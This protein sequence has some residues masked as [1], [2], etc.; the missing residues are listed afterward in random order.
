MDRLVSNYR[1]AEQLSKTLHIRLLSAIEFFVPELKGQLRLT[2]EALRGRS[3]N[4]PVS[5]TIPSTSR[6]AFLFA[7]KAGSE[8]KPHIGVGM[9]AQVQ[10][11]FRADELTTIRRR[12]VDIPESH[13]EPI[14]IALGTI[15]LTKVKRKQFVRVTF[16]EHF[17]TFMLLRVL[18]PLIND[19]DQL[20]FGFSY[21]QFHGAIQ[22]YDTAFGLHIGLSGHSGRACFATEAVII[23]NKPTPQVMREGRWL[24]E[25]SFRTYLDAIGANAAQAKFASRGLREAADFCRARIFDYLTP[26]SL[27]KHYGQLAEEEAN[28]FGR[29]VKVEAEGSLARPPRRSAATSLLDTS[30]G[31][32]LV[33]S[34]GGLV[35][36]GDCRSRAS[37]GKGGRG[38]G[39]G[40]R[41]VSTGLL[42]LR[43]GAGKA[44]KGR[45]KKGSILGK[46]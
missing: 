3:L 33:P 35:Q 43:A 19:P 2:K 28:R 38:K 21:W 13:L 29:P 24:S 40:T 30:R 32:G 31:K 18:V 37:L 44:A 45:G 6:I 8:Q 7:A 23:H 17:E 16:E 46:S 39:E 11:G 5:H 27:A 36:S 41:T 15:K 34:A 9:I 22:K 1:G 20:V 14:L 26:C 42:L 12:D 10:L 4:E 25:T